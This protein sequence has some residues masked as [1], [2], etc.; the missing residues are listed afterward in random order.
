MQFPPTL[1]STAKLCASAIRLGIFTIG[2]NMS[3]L[4]NA[5]TTTATQQVFAAESAFAKTMADRNLTAF[6]EFLSEEA[7]FFAG[8]KPLRGKAQIVEE[9]SAYFKGPKPPFSWVPDQ[10]EVLN[11]GKLALS[12]GPVRDPDGK[13]IARFNSIWRLENSGTWKVVFD[14]GSP[15]SPGPQ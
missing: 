14:K 10:V 12:T 8:T 3:L 2:I 11:S 13:I 4:A 15:A 6:A 1:R 9:W 7:I 5:D